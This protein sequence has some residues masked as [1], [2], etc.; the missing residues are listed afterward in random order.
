MTQ[1]DDTAERNRRARAAARLRGIRRSKWTHRTV[2]VLVV[3]VVVAV[4]LPFVVYAAPGVIGGEAGFVVLSGS[5]SP[6]MEVGDVVVVERV[7]PDRIAVGDVVSFERP[8][9]EVPVTHRVVAVDEDHIGTYY[10]TKGDAAETVDATSV[11]PG[12]V[13]GRLMEFDVPY[14]GPTQLVIPWLGSAILFVNTPVGFALAVALPIAGLLLIEVR[15]LVRATN[16]RRGDDDGDDDG[17]GDGDDDGDHRGGDGGT[18]PTAGGAVAPVGATNGD[19]VGDGVVLATEA[20]GARGADGGDA[21]TVSFT[22]R[23][24]TATT[25]ALGSFAVYSGAIA[26]LTGIGWTVAVFVLVVGGFLFAVGVRFAAPPAPDGGGP[27]AT[28]S[29]ATDGT[30]RI[31][32]TELPPALRSAPRVP[33]DGLSEL[34]AVAT[35]ADRRIVED[36]AGEGYFLPDGDVV[37]H[38]PAEN[39]GTADD[40]PDDQN[41]ECPDPTAGDADDPTAGDPGVEAPR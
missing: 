3:L 38:A 23:D 7:D 35:A 33:V 1:D 8:G 40:D 19:G 34:V 37:F 17:D 27:P 6:T 14:A 13:V 28:V 36:A 26:F 12:A 15:R 4:A 24:L 2:N 11:R 29:P 31:V 22:K 21:A 32:A 30:G 20:G 5:M 18:G 16:V 10:R 41:G 39:A 9:E 25:V